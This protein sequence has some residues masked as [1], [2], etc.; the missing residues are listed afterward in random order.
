MQ[1]VH[2]HDRYLTDAPLDSQRLQQSSVE[3]IAEYNAG[4]GPFERT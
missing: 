4:I 2:N 1:D 3:Q